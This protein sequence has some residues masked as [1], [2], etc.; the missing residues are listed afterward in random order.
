MYLF[1]YFLR[2]VCK[3]FYVFFSWKGL[4]PG[5]KEAASKRVLHAYSIP[6]FLWLSSKRKADVTTAGVLGSSRAVLK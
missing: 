2:N 5:K 1:I 3:V 6:T 4:S